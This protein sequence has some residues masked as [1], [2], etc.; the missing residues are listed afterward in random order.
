MSDKIKVDLV[1][2]FSNI[3]DEQYVVIKP[4]SALPVYAFGEDIDIFCYNP[5]DMIERI[6]TFL[7][8]Y[9]DE[10]SNVKVFDTETKAHIDF[11]SSGQIE[12]R[13][14]IYKELPIYKNILLKRA[15]FS[16]VIESSILDE[17]Q[18][19]TGNAL[20]RIPS[21]VDDIILRYVEYHEYYAQR[22]DKIK[23][24]EY[25]QSMFDENE[26][27]KALDKLHYY[28][29]FP[30]AVYKSK[31]YSER[32]FEKISYYNA[33]FV[34]LKHLYGQGGFSAVISKLR[35]KLG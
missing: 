34:K 17:R 29:A 23:H 33:L 14:D 4:S 28:T 31:S 6:S 1:S 15:F 18:S 30:T 24:I 2:F 20:I 10:S 12:I 22:P 35:G 3:Q 8:Q 5:T 13:F 25:I 11:V 16:S 21:K 27:S 26:K 19:I 32:V 7:A 9:I